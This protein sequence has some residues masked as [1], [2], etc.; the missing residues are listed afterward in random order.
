M[1][2][3]A[4]LVR[5]IG[6][7]TLAAL[8]INSVIG[9]GIFGVP[10]TVAA[11]IGPAAPFGYLIAAVG[12]G[13]I[14]ACLAEVASQFREAG[15][16]YLYA[17]V[18]FGR[19]AGIQMGWLA[20]LV[21]LSSAAASVNL[22]VI[23]LA[24]FWPPVKQPWP[25]AAVMTLLLGVLAVVNVRGV[26]AGARVSNFFTVAK[27]V[28]LVALILVGLYFLGGK[29]PVGWT[30]A[31][32]EDWLKALLVL[33][34]AYGGFEAA[35]Y[36]LGEAK[37]PKRDAP[38]AL[39]VALGTCTAVYTLIHLVVMGAL[40]DPTIS[41]RPLA[42]AARVF[43]GAGGAAFIAL[44]AMISTYGYLSG[45]MLSAPRLT[46][47]LAEQRDFP[48]FFARIHP[49]FRT[50]HI[51]IVIYMFMV[52]GLALYGSFL[53]NAVLST[54]ARML[55]YAIVCAALLA[56]RRKQPNAAEFRLPGGPV[57]AVL[58]LAFSLLLVARMG[59]DE[60]IALAATA[61]LAFANWW[62]VR[63]RDAGGTTVV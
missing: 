2:H 55:T 43:L 16:V 40:R 63:R 11:L 19:Y 53:W 22:F 6:R 60:V 10:N 59:R 35:L 17:H 51:S 9:S 12:I 14:M 30:H 50:P 57:F 32:G 7:W 49:V 1:Q 54:V 3:Q 4:E 56:L 25:R 42:E 47:A 36:P 39:F 31:S 37:N 38:F 28:P 44:G 5:A 58:G 18:A 48:S 27:L 41:D 20:W 34:F 13:V 23:Y 21:R 62:W 52:W 46:Y 33:A 15:G 24:E 29:A 26:R 61:A 45:Q 8:V